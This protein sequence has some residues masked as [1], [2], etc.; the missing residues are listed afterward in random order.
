MCQS[1]P[2]SKVQYVQRDGLT[3]IKIIRGPVLTA[4]DTTA[5]NTKKASAR[6]PT[7]H[8]THCLCNFIIP[9]AERQDL[10]VEAERQLHARV[11]VANVAR[12]NLEQR[13][14]SDFTTNTTIIMSPRPQDHKTTRPQPHYYHTVVLRLRGVHD[15]SL[16]HVTM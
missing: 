9:D 10:A 16:N 7:A 3:Y 15:V 6:E 1:S 14:C 8:S 13:R 4:D 5:L 12:H 2:I 11:R